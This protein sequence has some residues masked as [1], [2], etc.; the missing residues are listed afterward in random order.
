MSLHLICVGK[1]KNRELETLC[2]DYQKRI[3]SPKLQIHETKAYSEHQEKEAE[4]VIQKIKDIQAGSSFTILLTEWG[5]HF[6]SP[7]LSHWISD[8]LE[9][10]QQIIFIIAGAAGPHEKLKQFCHAKLSLS[11]LTF[12]HKL[13]RLLLTEQ[14]YRVQTIRQKHPYHN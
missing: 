4:V 9:K 10:Y 5:E 8:K 3:N 2:H 7:E 12:P 1:L 11:K 14:I 13:A 6:E